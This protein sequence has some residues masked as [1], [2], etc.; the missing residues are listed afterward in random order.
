MAEVDRILGMVATID[1]YVGSIKA[2]RQGQ[3]D[4]NAVRIVLVGMP[5]RTLCTGTVLKMQAA[6]P[7]PSGTHSLGDGDTQAVAC[8]M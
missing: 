1:S 3:S 7:R 5:A 4:V 2:R 8:Y 6:M